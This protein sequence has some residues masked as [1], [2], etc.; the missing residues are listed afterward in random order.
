VINWSSS[1]N[2]SDHLI[3][4][5][6]GFFCLDVFRKGLLI[7]RFEEENLIVDNS[8]QIHAKLLGGAVSGQSVTKI[9]FGSNGLAPAGGN[10]LLTN[11]YIKAVDATTYPNTNQVQFAFSLSSA[12][13]NGL[14]IMEFGLLTAANTLYARRVRGAPL[15]KDADLSFSGTWTIVF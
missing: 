11:G 1:V 7:E 10:T 13:A 3:Q 15:N 6:K 2:L 12:E 9:G 14:A 8:K 4:A 5:P